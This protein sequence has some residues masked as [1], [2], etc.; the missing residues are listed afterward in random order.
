MEVREGVNLSGGGFGGGGT[1]WWVRYRFI[2]VCREL[3][4]DLSY[5]VLFFFNFRRDVFLVSLERRTGEYS[6]RCL[7][8][9]VEK[10]GRV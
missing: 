1:R 4:E 8:T 9:N 5:C 2:R 10:C 6:L 3:W 7:L